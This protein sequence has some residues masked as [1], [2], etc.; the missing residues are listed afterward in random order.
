MTFWADFGNNG[1][2]ET[3]LGMAS[4]QVF[5]IAKCPVDGLE[6]SVFLP[7]NFNHYRRPCDEGPRWYL[8]AQ[9][10][11]GTTSHLASIPITFRN[12]VIERS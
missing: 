9:S 8:S 3:C 11:R 7:V 4:V 2:F 10:C 6:Y 1:S 12:G 5:D